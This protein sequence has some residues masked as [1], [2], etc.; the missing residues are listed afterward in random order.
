MQILLRLSSA[1]L[2]LLALASPAIAN[3]RSQAHGLPDITPSLV[4][5]AVDAA[6][7]V[8]THEIDAALLIALCWG[9]SRC[10]PKTHDHAGCGVLQVNPKDLDEPATMCAVWAETIE[11]GMAAGVRELEVLLADHRVHHNMR[12]AL[13]Y[14]ACGNKAFDGTCNAHK[15]GWV[16]EAMYH[17]RVLRGTRG[18]WTMPRS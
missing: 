1:L 12:L 14:R 10:E 3:L 15:L 9:E 11:A 7:A 5:E 6:I 13:Q 16:E 2:I 4:D 8:E 17:A 18:S